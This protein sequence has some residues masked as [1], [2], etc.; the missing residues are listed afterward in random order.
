MSILFLALAFKFIFKFVKNSL[1][2]LNNLNS[3]IGKYL[4]NNYLSYSKGGIF[5]VIGVE[6]VNKKN[7]PVVKATNNKPEIPETYTK[8]IEKN[9]D[10][11]EPFTENSPTGHDLSKL[12][13]IK[14]SFEDFFKNMSSNL[15]DKLS[16]V[17]VTYSDCFKG[18]KIINSENYSKGYDFLNTIQTTDWLSM[19]VSS[20]SMDL[21]YYG[22][23]ASIGIMGVLLAQSFREIFVY[24]A[25]RNVYGLP[26]NLGFNA[27]VAAGP[28]QTGRA[29]WTAIE[30]RVIRIRSIYDYYNDRILALN[31]R[32]DINNN[33]IEHP[34]LI[35]GRLDIT[36]LNNIIIEFENIRNNP[37]SDLNRELRAYREDVE[38]Y[39][40]IL[41]QLR[42]IDHNLEPTVP[43][44]I[45]NET[46][47]RVRGNMTRRREQY[48]RYNNR[49]AGGNN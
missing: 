4:D 10:K 43:G 6:P 9:I 34:H 48:N 30:H 21:F 16:N 36:L 37:N 14:Y 35:N 29:L 8:D 42:P 15:T 27:P 2:S 32:Y 3:T 41:R 13:T 47:R 31:V 39:R 11:I 38:R 17:S 1:K 23:G 24:M 22:K 5:L 25:D 45:L 40:S 7:I 49:Q 18:G 44:T 19:L 26:D 28:V 46:L 20:N 12:D 33:L